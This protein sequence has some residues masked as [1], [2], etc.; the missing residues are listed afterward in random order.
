MF[1]NTINTINKEVMKTSKAE[2]QKQIEY[3]LGDSNLAK[4]T[5]FREKITE[6]KDGY[7][8]FEVF[9]NC[10]KIKKMGLDITKMKEACVGSTEVETSKDG[11]MVRRKDNKELPACTGSN[12]KRDVKAVSKQA[13]KVEEKKVEE[14]VEEE[15]ERD[16]QGRIIFK[17]VDFE[18]PKIIHFITQDRDA[19]KDENYK[20]NWKDLEV[21]VKEKFDKLK[22][23]YSRADKYEGDLAISQSK[24]CK[25]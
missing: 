5:F 15:V 16:D 18:D 25:E 17:P 1:K 20:V 4:D 24:L 8:K 21:M 19:E 13:S 2:I 12:K 14:Q 10:N 9:L 11:V 23:V 7:V 22:V 6:H 3:Y